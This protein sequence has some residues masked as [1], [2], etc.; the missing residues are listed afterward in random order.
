MKTS[1]IQ[2]K[3]CLQDLY[4][5]K[6]KKTLNTTTELATIDLIDLRKFNNDYVTRCQE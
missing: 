5:W 3:I 1:K 6:K 4:I 2:K